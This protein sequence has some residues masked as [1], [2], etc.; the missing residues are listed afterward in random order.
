MEN[1]NNIQHHNPSLTDT[2]IEQNTMSD[3]DSEEDSVA[4]DRLLGM[5]DEWLQLEAEIRSKAASLQGELTQQKKVNEE[6][7][8]QLAEARKKNDI[9]SSNEELVALLQSK[10]KEIAALKEENAAL[11]KVSMIDSH[12]KFL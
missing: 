7:M 8:Q 12:S 10:D 5:K 9:P 2:E 1:N 6:L 4:L 11:M 3:G